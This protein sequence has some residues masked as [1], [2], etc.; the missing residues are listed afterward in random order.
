MISDAP[1]LGVI[2][3][4][5]VD[6]LLPKYQLH[7]IGGPSGAGKTTWLFQQIEEWRNGRDVLG[8]KSNPEPFVYVACDRSIDNLEQT[9]L[10][11]GTAPFPILSLIDSEDIEHRLLPV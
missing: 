9:R 2:V 10:R 6:K 3:E 4:Y 7:L 5:L 1:T 11:T 8:H